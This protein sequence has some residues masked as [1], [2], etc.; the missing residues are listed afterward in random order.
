MV[1]IEKFGNVYFVWLT[2]N[3]SDKIDEDPT[4]G[5]IK[6][7]QGRLNGAP[8]KVEKI[9]HF[10]IGDVITSLH[11]PS[12]VSSGRKCILNGMVMGSSGAFLPFTSRDDVDFFSHP[13]MYKR[14][15][16]SFFILT[17]GEKKYEERV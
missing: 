14:Q 3:V 4:S 2:Q 5:K 1:G 16:P 10:Y 13:E 6:W 12:D 15:E 9:V 7:E 8:N 11:K 17:Q